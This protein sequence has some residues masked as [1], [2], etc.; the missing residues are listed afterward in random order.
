MY[1]ISVQLMNLGGDEVAAKD[2]ASGSWTSV[3]AAA[4]AWASG[5][6]ERS[7]DRDAY[8]VFTTTMNRAGSVEIDEFDEFASPV[9]MRLTEAMYA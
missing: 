8:V 6:M 7:D 5:A 4:K 2:V 1:V 3:W 9:E